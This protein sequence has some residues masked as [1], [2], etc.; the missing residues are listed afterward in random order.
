VG[1]ARR[2]LRDVRRRAEREWLQ[3]QVETLF[4]HDARGR[5]LAVNEPDGPPAP[6]FFL[7]RSLDGDIWRVRHDVPAELA[8]TLRSILGAEPP[9]AD[10]RQL[11]ATWPQLCAALAAHAPVEQVWHGPAW[12]FPAAITPPNAVATVAVDDPAILLPSFPGW[13]AS[14]SDNLPCAAVLVDG[15]AVAVCASARTSSLAAEA[16]VDT[17]AEHRGRGYA[18]A[19][20]AGWAQAVRA[21]GR[22]PLYSTSWDN[23]A[24]QGVA[25]RLEL[26]LY[27]VD[28]HIT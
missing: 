16:G 6:R 26:V 21:T 7:G 11:P 14:L 20:V 15:R 17:L 1:I 27:G 23:L 2:L 8:M 22:E 5:L 18:A 10:P 3:L 28:L 19:A 9:L 24:S 12:H 13:A 25:R 4:Q